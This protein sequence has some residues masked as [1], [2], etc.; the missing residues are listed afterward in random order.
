MP[1]SASLPGTFKEAKKKATLSNESWA[2]NLYGAV[3]GHERSV[4]PH[5]AVCHSHGERGKTLWCWHLNTSFI[6]V[7]VQ[8]GK[9]CK[10]R[11]PERSLIILTFFEKG[12]Y[13]LQVV[14]SSKDHNSRFLDLLLCFQSLSS[15][16]HFTFC[17]ILHHF[18][19]HLK[20]KRAKKTTDFG[21]REDI[22]HL[23]E[24]GEFD[25]FFFYWKEK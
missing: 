8:E 25:V 2:L 5:S 17:F 9:D 20:C 12:V 14:P 10:S 23:V 3:P 1:T 16:I 7:T 24:K 4:A 13:T 22:C 19:Y 6:F 21:V 18:F 15:H 11:T